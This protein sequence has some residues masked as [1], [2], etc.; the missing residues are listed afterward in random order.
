MAVARGA[1][2]ILIEKCRTL[3][4]FSPVLLERGDFLMDWSVFHVNGGLRRW[5]FV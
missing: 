3:S 5:C 2:L 4:L 1:S